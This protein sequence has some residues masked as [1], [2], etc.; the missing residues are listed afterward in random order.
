MKDGHEALGSVILDEK[1][2]L[3][4]PKHLILSSIIRKKM[5][6]DKQS[7][8]TSDFISIRVGEY[9]LHSIEKRHAIHRC[10]DQHLHL[11]R[12]GLVQ[13]KVDVARIYV[14]FRRGRVTC[15]IFYN[16]EVL[17]ADQNYMYKNRSTSI[18]PQS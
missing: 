4:H 14:P 8:S 13:G 9:Y 3:N 11:R 17:T 16:T 12:F 15:R 5:K 10:P 2:V 7:I 6:P 18:Q 1:P